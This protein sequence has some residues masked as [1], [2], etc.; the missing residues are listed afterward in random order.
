[1]QSACDVPSGDKLI[2]SSLLPVGHYLAIVQQLVRRHDL[3]RPVVFLSS[4]D[5]SAIQ[6]FEAAAR[7]SGLQVLTYAYPRPNFRCGGVDLQSLSLNGSGA[8]LGVKGSWDKR[9]Q[10]T[11]VDT[12]LCPKVRFAACALVSPCM[13]AR[14]V[15]RQ[16]EHS[17]PCRAC[18]KRHVARDCVSM[19]LHSSRH[20]QLPTSYRSRHLTAPD[21]LHGMSCINLLH[22]ASYA[23]HLATYILRSSAILPESTTWPSPK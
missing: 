17:L 16:L 6:L 5:A 4:E 20:L 23:S 12:Q 22:L 18:C 1:M 8:V 2:E 13:P 21:I 9:R 11:Y 15:L 7:G 19:L 14:R 10:A 3:R